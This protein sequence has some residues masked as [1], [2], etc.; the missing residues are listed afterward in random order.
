L[1]LKHLFEVVHLQSNLKLLLNQVFTMRLNPQLKKVL[2]G[3]LFVAVIYALMA[4]ALRAIGLENAQNFIRKTGNWAPLIFVVLCAI[5]LILAPLSGSSLFVAGGALFGRETGFILSYIATL[6]GCSINYWIS[7]RFGRGVA[8]RFIG[9][10]NLDELDDFIKRLKSH[11]SIFYMI[12]IMPLSQDIVS[13]AVG[14]TKIKY[15]HFL[16][17]LVISGAVVV[18]A[19]IYL[20][21][22]LL[23]ALI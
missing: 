20:G 3:L 22:S 4:L 16:I 5:S 11:H 17:A 10:K 6:A 7:R 23:E 18:S 1:S 13:Y 19:Y 2:L 15:T 14:L 21:S 8:S 12:L 9:K